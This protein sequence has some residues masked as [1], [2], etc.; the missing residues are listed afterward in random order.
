MSFS[1][2]ALLGRMAL[3]R[4]RAMPLVPQLFSNLRERDSLTTKAKLCL[5][6]YPVV[7]TSQYQKTLSSRQIDIINQRASKLCRSVQ[8]MKGQEFSEFSWEVSAWQYVFGLIREDEWFKMDKKAYKFV[9]EG[10]DGKKIVKTRTPDAT[11]GLAT[12][13][14]K[15]LHLNR[16]SM[17]TGYQADYINKEL[18]ERLSQDR[19]KSMTNNLNCSLVVDGSWGNANIV[20][21]FAVYEAKKREADYRNAKQQIQHACQIYL[22]MLDDLARNPDNVAKYQSA[23]SSHC[24]MFAFVSY[25]S[26]WAV[27]VA[28]SSSKT[29]NIELLWTGD[30]ASFTSALNLLCIVDQ[31]HDYAAKYHRPYVL[32]HL[33]PWLAW[34][35]KHRDDLATL[36]GVKP[37]H[38]SWR[39]FESDMTLFRKTKLQQAREQKMKLHALAGTSGSKKSRERK[40]TGDISTKNRVVKK[41]QQN[42]EQKCQQE[43]QA[44]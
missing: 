28:W 18:D 29:C 34:S 37:N 42:D 2:P 44:E 5:R 11:F 15:T 4:K 32:D 33:T 13:D 31:I 27:Y 23:N 35:E 20:F 38:Q 6:F 17:A 39:C 10:T 25:G 26:Q 12:Y 7:R 19:L 14:P 22:S 24:Q 8:S 1:V 16:Q 3:P 9:E 41:V 43:G 30:V 40:V 36:E 21:P